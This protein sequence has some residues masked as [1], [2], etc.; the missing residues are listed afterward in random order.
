MK[1]SRRRFLGAMAAAR[2]ASAEDGRF[3]KSICSVIFPPKTPL[4]KMFADAKAAGFDAIELRLDVDLF[5]AADAGS[6]AR[7]HGLQIASLWV[8]KALGEHPLNSPDASVR[9]QGVADIQRAADVAAGIGCGALLLVPGQIGHG[10][11]LFA[12][13]EETWKRFTDEL[14]KC[15]P[16]AANRRVLL[17]VEN[18]W[19]L[20][21][22]SPTE[23]RSFV[24]QF[25]SPWLQAHFDMGNVLRFGYPEDWVRTL[26]PR[27]RRV[28]VKDF[29][30]RHGMEAGHFV[31]L[32]TG[33][34]NFQAVMTALRDAGYRGFLSPEINYDANEPDQLAAVSKQLDRII[35]MA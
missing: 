20:F 34:V 2:A 23:M 30:L 28:H 22:M 9:A 10:A 27:I 35:A 1:L 3:T 24:D 13:Y 11:K 14:T 33:D 15:I 25:H 6:M 17:T 32:L 7:D 26:G 29:R 12:G 4:S 21:L 5:T 8:S 18:V 19:N 31:P 16:A